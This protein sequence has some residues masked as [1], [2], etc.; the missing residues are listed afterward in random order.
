MGV[1]KNSSNILR[2]NKIP[3]NESAWK[4]KQ[5]RDAFA[6]VVFAGTEGQIRKFLVIVILPRSGNETLF[7][8]EIA[9]CLF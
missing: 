9:P 6:C 8:F 1:N 7:L 4:R 3:T 5:S 2:K